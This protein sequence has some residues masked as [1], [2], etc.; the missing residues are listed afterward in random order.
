MKVVGKMKLTYEIKDLNLKE[1]FISNK[2]VTSKVTQLFLT[3][4]YDQYYSYGTC[5]IERKDVDLIVQ[6]IKVLSDLL[7]IQ[8]SSELPNLIIRVNQMDFNFVLPAIDMALHDLIGKVRKISISQYF[9]F[10][11]D[12][13]LKTSISVGVLPQNE[14]IEKVSQLKDW[15]ILKFKISNIEEIKRVCS[16]REIYEGKIWIDGNGALELEEAMDALELLEKKDVEIFEQPIP[17][18]NK[19]LLK[20]LKSSTSI[21][22]AADE[23]CVHFSDIRDLK[24]CVDIVNIK[25]IKSKSLYR[26]Y[27]MIKEAEKYDLEVLLG[28]KTES[29]LGVTA[30]AQMGATV[31]YLDL[32]GHLDILNDP[33]IGLEVTRGEFALPKN[34]GLG[35]SIN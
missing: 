18:G 22:I 34:N 6:E 15:P 21:K 12:K 23:D 33:F 29:V 26:T 5:L 7:S 19:K 13:K 25:I 20:V 8:S 28:C 9:N 2:G 16:I 17:A 32:D 35:V 10:A 30:M 27:E 31:N 3:L 4:Q 1:P 14:L 24:E 11:N